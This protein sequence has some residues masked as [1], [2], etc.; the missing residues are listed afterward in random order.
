MAAEAVRDG[1][2]GFR[3]GFTQKRGHVELA[4]SSFLDDLFPQDGTIAF[5]IVAIM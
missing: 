3:F 2:H 1:A 5:L 4:H